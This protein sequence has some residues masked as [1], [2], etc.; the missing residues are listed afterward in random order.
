MSY[1]FFLYRSP[2]SSLCTVFDSI[3]SNID[4]VLSINPSANVFVFG[5]FNIHHKDWLTYSGGTDRPGELCYNFSL[6]NDLTQ[7]VNFPTRIPDC[8]SH[9]PALLDLFL[10]SDASICS[11]MAFPPLGNS[12]HVVVSV[13]IDFPVNSKQEAPFYRVA[14]DYSRADWDGLR[15]HLRDIPWE[16]IFKL[17]ASTAASEFCEW[18]QVGIDVCIPHRKYQVKPHSSP[19]IK[20]AYATK[21]KESITS[22]KLGS[23][24]FWRI[25][26]SVLN[27]GKS[28]IPPL[29]NGPK[30]LSSASDKAKLF[31][32]NFSKNS[33]LDDSGISLPVFPSRTNLKLHNISI[34]PKM[35]NKVITNLDSSKA[36]GPD[37]ILVVVL[38]NCEPEL[39]YILAKLFN[40]CLKESC[41]PDCWKVSS[42]VPVFKNVGERPTAKNYR[43]VSLLFVVSKV[44]EKLVNN[45]IVD[46]LEK[47]GLFSDFQ[48]GF[49]SSRSTADLLTVVSDR[50]ARAFNRSGATRVVALDIS[51][52][53]DRVWHA[54]LLHKLKSYGI[55]GQIFGLIS[56][57][58]SNRRLRVVLDGKSSQEYPVNAGV[59]Q[60]SI[61]GPILFLLYINDLPD[62]VIC[63]IAI[64]ADD[65]TLYSKL[66]MAFDLWQQLELASELE[67]DLRD[68]WT[69]AGSG[70]L[71]SMLEK[72]N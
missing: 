3:S 66:I 59:P 45:R 42:V 51:K 10:S 2:S 60:G 44:F 71:I 57:I 54:G 69:G 19:F 53:F 65:T 63:N 8:D 26:N 58:L 46:H 49:R 9:S 33:N 30:V 12:D 72:L 13:S 62:N 55:S 29:F 23:R 61:L 50:I 41:F 43:P 4:E 47:C 48:Y 31:A 25:A 21:T 11:T 32:K 64:Y 56:P 34:T 40:K 16:D 1:F 22:Q 18:V 39:S 14:Y 36:S 5:D 68:T 7:I 17:G 70:L 67:S 24:D 28:A 35:V 20:R 38:K 52:A 37:C 15:D 6:S 27:K